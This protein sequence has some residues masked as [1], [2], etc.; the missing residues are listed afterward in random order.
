MQAFIEVRARVLQYSSDAVQRNASVTAS[1]LHKVCRV[2][3][4]HVS[5]YRQSETARNLAVCGSISQCRQH[6]LGYCLDAHSSNRVMSTLVSA[7]VTC[8]FVLR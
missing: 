7:A 8:K 2:A 5:Y 6:P 1:A 3:A 4:A